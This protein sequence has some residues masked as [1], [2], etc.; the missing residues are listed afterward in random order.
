MEHWFAYIQKG[1]VVFA[2]I[3]MLFVAVAQLAGAVKVVVTGPQLLKV[4]P[5]M[6][7]MLGIVA[8]RFKL[9]LSGV[10]WAKVVRDYGRECRIWGLI[11]DRVFLRG[12]GMDS[13]CETLS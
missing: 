13:C 10:L 11:K 1:A 9:R 12:V 2:P 8:M 7:V 3:L 5:S 6:V 4:K